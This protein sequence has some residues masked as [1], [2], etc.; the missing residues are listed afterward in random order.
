MSRTKL[1]LMSDENDGQPLL[2][3]KYLK[4]HFHIEDGL[5]KTVDG[6]DMSVNRGQALGLIGE[7]GCGK[8]AADRAILRLIEPAVRRKRLILEGNVLSPLDLPSGCRFHT[9][10]PYVM[11]H[12]SQEE[13]PFREYENGYWVACWLLE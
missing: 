7:S 13:P 6:V 4:T 11:D 2:E 5:V 10:C 3:V 1:T 12:C 8:T 9:P